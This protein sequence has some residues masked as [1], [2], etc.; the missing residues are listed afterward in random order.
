MVFGILLVAL[1]CSA[2]VSEMLGSRG[3]EVVQRGGRSE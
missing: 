1:V 2:V 3:T